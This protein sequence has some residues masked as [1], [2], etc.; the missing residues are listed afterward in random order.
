MT[1]T[2][3]TDDFDKRDSISGGFSG[4]V[5]LEGKERFFRGDL[6]RNL[7]EA[8]KRILDEGGEEIDEIVFCFRV[9][10]GQF[11]RRFLLRSGVRLHR[12]IIECNEKQETSFNSPVA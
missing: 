7:T 11:F 4:N 12:G 5:F 1:L 8:L 2:I 3:Y 9:G 6:S 10:E